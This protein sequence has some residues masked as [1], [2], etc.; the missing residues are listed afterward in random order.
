[1]SASSDDAE[2]RA[3]GEDCGASDD[4][5][6]G[7]RSKASVR[8]IISDRDPGLFVVDREASR[9]FPID[10]RCRAAATRRHHR[11]IKH[12]RACR[13]QSRTNERLTDYCRRF[14]ERRGSVKS[15]L[16]MSVHD[17]QLSPHCAG[18]RDHEAYRKDRVLQ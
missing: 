17:G 8:G 11:A 5:A 7:H 14:A 12:G 15:M 13:P 10:H 9:A 3:F 18:V 2:S 16:T 6:Y 1:M 4:E